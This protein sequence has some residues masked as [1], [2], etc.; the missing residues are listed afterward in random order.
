VAQ[1]VADTAP[2]P[3]ADQLAGDT[4]VAGGV[5]DLSDEGLGTGPGVTAGG[6]DTADLNGNDTLRPAGD[7]DGSFG[8]V[9]DAFDLTEGLDDVDTDGAGFG[10]GDVD[11]DDPVG[12]TVDDLGDIDDDAVSGDI[13]DGPGSGDLADDGP[14][15]FGGGS[16]AA[17]LTELD[18]DGGAG[19]LDD[20]DEGFEI[21]GLDGG[22]DTPAF[23]DTPGYD[24]G[25][26]GVDTLGVG[27]D[28]GGGHL[29]DGVD[30]GPDDGPGDDPSFDDIG[31]F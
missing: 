14:V 20:T 3:L 28:D 26:D 11:L 22:V 13:G 10:S 9:D 6:A 18:D 31:S 1:A 29:H 16:E 19:Q 7:G 4:G 17:Q 15:D 5:D 30:D 23:D 25:I 21:D 8:G 12:A 27:P 2:G 24:D